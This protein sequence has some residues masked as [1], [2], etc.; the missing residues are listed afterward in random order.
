MNKA[1]GFFAVALF[2][3]FVGISIFLIPGYGSY[4]NPNVPN[5]YLNNALVDTGSANVVNSI[6]WDYRGYDTMGE[7]TVLIVATIGVVLLVGRRVS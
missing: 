1:V 6:V 3:V 5:Y 4:P 7:E 2:A